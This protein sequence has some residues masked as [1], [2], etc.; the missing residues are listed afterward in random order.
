MRELREVVEILN[1]F[2]LNIVGIDKIIERMND[3]IYFLYDYVSGQIILNYFSFNEVKEIMCNMK[4]YKVI[5]YDFIFA[6][7]VKDFV[8]VLCESYCIFFNYILDIGKI[9]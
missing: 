3:F 9:F 1:D 7:V 6:R 8:E 2:F 5:G 4:I